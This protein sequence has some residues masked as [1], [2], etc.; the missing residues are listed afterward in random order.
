[1]LLLWVTIVLPTA[2]ILLVPLKLK[3]WA[4]AAGAIVHL[5]LA[6]YLGVHGDQLC[7]P[8]VLSIHCEATFLVPLVWIV[9]L[10]VFLVAAAANIAKWLEQR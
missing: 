6:Y 7:G 3:V 1:M 10:T 8:G 2:T 9:S 5:C 4:A